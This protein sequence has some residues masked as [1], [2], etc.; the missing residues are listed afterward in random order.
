MATRV[1]TLG[2]EYKY[3]DAEGKQH[4]IAEIYADT[5]SDISGK[6]EFNAGNGMIV[7][8]PNSTA[9]VVKSG[10][11]YVMGGDSKWYDSADGS[12]VQ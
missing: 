12:E 10:K 3:R 8:D 9:Y 6:T 11:I 2:S 4:M 1:D 7:A 5:S